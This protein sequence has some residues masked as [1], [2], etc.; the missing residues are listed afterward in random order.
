M[1]SRRLLTTTALFALVA[2]A[3]SGAIIFAHQDQER[4]R[5]AVTIDPEIVV[6]EGTVLSVLLSSF[7]NTRST[8]VGDHFYAEVAYPIWQQQRLII[9]RGSTVR[10]LVTEVVRP[11][12]LK[13]KGRLAVRVED[14]LLPNG[15][16]RDLNASFRGIHGPGTEKIDRK[17]ETV[18]AASTKGA[19]VG[20]VVG[21]TGTGAMIGAI[22]DHGSGAGIGA[23]IGAA[24]GLVTV[25][26]GRGQDLVLEPGTEFELEL[27]QPLKFVYGELD[28]NNAQLNSTRAFQRQPRSAPAT[29]TH[30]G[31]MGLPIPW[32]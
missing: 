28:F 14:I 5:Q 11:G 15:V 17:T 26:F 24:V 10:G 22:A 7:L 18:E 6:P 4:P 8:Q 2:A 9:P 12:K 32:P 21:T 16:K 1:K 13:G 29:G 31:I 20:Q 27:K 25:L 23:G 30:R 19:D 3:A